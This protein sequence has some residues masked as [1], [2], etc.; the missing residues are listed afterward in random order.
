MPPESSAGSDRLRVARLLD[1]H[2]LTPNTDLGQHF[3][4]D[5]NLVD[6]AVREGRVGPD[7]V[8]M[9]VGA[10]VGVLTRVLA[11]HASH[12]HAVEIDRRLEGALREA[13]EGH[14]N[15][16]L[17]W[18]DAMKVSIAKL[19]PA[20]TR[21]VA[22]LPYDIATPI[23][24]E[25]LATGP[26]IEQVC[27]MVQREVA[28]RWLARVGDSHYGAASVQLGLQVEPSFR[29]NVGR[30][31]FMPRPRVD[32]ALVAFRRTG[33]PISPGLRTLVRSGFAHRRKTLTNALGMAGAERSDVA[34]ALRAIGAP[35]NVRPERLA[36]DDFARLHEELGWPK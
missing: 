18:D 26:Q 16:S 3:L 2:G 12:V 7:D 21:F 20:P 36:P 17:I 34:D 13:L 31:V 23:L 28:D 9:E 22:N 10:G 6:V 8:V 29:R 24:L 30:E 4:L 1:A 33:P 32:S 19:D 11:G 14:D 25:S 5:E 15:V 35:E 27:V